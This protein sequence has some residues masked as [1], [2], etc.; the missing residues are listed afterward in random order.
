MAPWTKKASVTVSPSC[1]SSVRD[2]EEDP[3]RVPPHSARDDEGGAETRVLV[4]IKDL[5][6]PCMAVLLEMAEQQ[7][8]YSQQG[9]LRVPCDAQRFEHVLNMARKSKVAR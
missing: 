1:V 6:E 8:G 9:V 3:Q 2:D 7:F 4:R 5:Q